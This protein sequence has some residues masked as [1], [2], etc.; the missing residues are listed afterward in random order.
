MLAPIIPIDPLDRAI[1]Q[2]VWRLP[3]ELTAE[4]DNIFQLPPVNRVTR[5]MEIITAA[6]KR[7]PKIVEILRAP[8]VLPGL[9]QMAHDR[10]AE[11]EAAEQQLNPATAA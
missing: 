10:R 9:K 4:M 1:G 3:L 5:L 7:D 11:H 6:A 2:I 8:D